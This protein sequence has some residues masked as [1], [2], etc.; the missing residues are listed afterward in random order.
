MEEHGY[1]PVL[2]TTSESHPPAMAGDADPRWQLANACGPRWISA[3]A[4]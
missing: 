1:F 4:T 3:E 2:G